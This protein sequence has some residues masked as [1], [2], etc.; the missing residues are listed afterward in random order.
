MAARE[1]LIIKDGGSIGD[2]V[3]IERIW[4]ISSCQI[5]SSLDPINP[6]LFKGHSR[7]RPGGDSD[8]CPEAPVPSASGTARA[9]TSANGG[10]DA[11]P[12]W[13]RR[14]SAGHWLRNWLRRRR[15]RKAAERQPI[16]ASRRFGQ[17]R[18]PPV[19]PHL[20]CAGPLPGSQPRAG[21]AR[22][23]RWPTHR[24]IQVGFFFFLGS[25]KHPIPIPI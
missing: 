22:R 11:T 8:L 6:H 13:R 19:D 25:G 12:K 3:I 17:V 10:A 23:R 2:G 16:L 24:R 4:Y 15:R 7:G 5:N 20:G 14:R 9:R 21:D 1:W 18:R